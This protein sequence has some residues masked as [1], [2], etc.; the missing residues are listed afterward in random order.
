MKK[1]VTRKMSKE[2]YQEIHIRES[3]NGLLTKRGS[4]SLDIKDKMIES[5]RS[6]FKKS[7]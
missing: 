1:T 4:T 2:Y 5:M 7:N 6:I 3:A